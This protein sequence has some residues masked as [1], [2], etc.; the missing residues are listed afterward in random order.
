MQQLL[1]QRDVSQYR[2]LGTLAGPEGKTGQDQTLIFWS[3]MYREFQ[4]I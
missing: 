2:L 1:R 4:D 3:K